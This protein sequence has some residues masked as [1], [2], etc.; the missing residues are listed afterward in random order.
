M[1]SHPPQSRSNQR[2]PT[3][4]HRRWLKLI[5]RHHRVVAAAFAACAMALGIAAVRAEP[6]TRD[7]LAAAHDLDSGQVVT[8]DDLELRAVDLDDPIRTLDLDEAVGRTLTGDVSRGEPITAA[9]AVDPRAL[10]GGESLVAIEV[11]PAVARMS[12]EGDVVD[13]L[14]LTEESAEPLL[15][16]AGVRVMVVDPG[17]SGSAAVVS[18]AA[19]ADVATSLATTALRTRMTLVTTS[20]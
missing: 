7:I 3:P 15:V 14:A 8:A 12:R 4:T 18:V 6:D 11:D 1:R 16:A 17:D 19:D 2:P 5:R 10:R 13:V 20:S 9:R